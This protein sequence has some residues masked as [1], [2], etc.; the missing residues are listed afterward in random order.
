M[1]WGQCLFHALTLWNTIGGRIGFRKSEH[2]IIAHAQHF[3][4]HDGL[5]HF[6]PPGKL[7]SPLQGLV[8]FHGSVLTADKSPAPPMSMPGI[9]LSSFLL[10]G[11]SVLWAIWTLSSQL[12]NKVNTMTAFLNWRP[13]AA[14]LLVCLLAYS[15]YQAYTFG[16]DRARVTQAAKDKTEA[17]ALK[18]DLAEQARNASKAA[19]NHAAELVAINQ[20]LGTAHEKIAQLSGRRCLDSGT[21]RM[22]NTIGGDQPGPAAARQP[23]GAPEA[24]APA[25]DDRF[26]TERDVAGYIATCRAWYAEV[27][28]QLNQ[29]LDIE[30]ARWPR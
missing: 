11:G 12:I 28:S 5:S 3:M 2:W 16:G 18:V 4:D 6:V 17:D 1:K 25:A 24:A 9:V 26:A 27:A 14:L 10:F 15:H 19:G 13:W 7:K 22:L 20:Q 29:I 23:A 30:D 8:G 21:V